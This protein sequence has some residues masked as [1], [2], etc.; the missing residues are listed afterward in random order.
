[1]WAWPSPRKTPCIPVK[2]R[3]Q[4]QA[5]EMPCVPVKKSSP[6]HIPLPATSVPGTDCPVSPQ[7]PEDPSADPVDHQLPDFGVRPDVPVAVPERRPAEGPGPQRGQPDRPQLGAPAGPDREDLGHPAGPGPGWVRHHGLPV[8]C[9]PAL[10]EPLLP[11]HHLQLLRQPHL[12]GRA[13]EPAAPHRGAEQAEPRAV[14]GTPGELW[15][16]A[17]HPA[18]GPPGSA[19]RP[20]QAAAVHIWAGQHGLVQR[21]PLSILWWPDLLRPWA[22]PVPLLH[23]RLAQL[24]SCRLCPRHW[25]TATQTSVHLE[26][27]QTTVSDSCSVH[28]GKGKVI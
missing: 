18:P 22:Q 19:A 4:L 17:W 9:P 28:A 2:V 13:G 23:A 6:A 3:G 1:M 20:A 16:C 24:T 21:Q 5:S 7:V 12:H 11:A 26:G 27:T 10:P 14:P 15:G 8:Q 25:D